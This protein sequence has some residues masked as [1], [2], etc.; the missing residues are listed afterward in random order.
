MEVIIIYAAILIGGDTSFVEFKGTQF[1]TMDKCYSFYNENKT[2][3]ESSL[4]NHLKQTSPNATIQ[5]I[6]CSPKNTFLNNRL[7]KGA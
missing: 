2:G 3:I 5:F 4:L 1:K 6:G 7:D